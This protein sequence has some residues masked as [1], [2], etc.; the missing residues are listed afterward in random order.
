[1]RAVRIHNHGSYDV[2]QH[3]EIPRPEPEAGQVLI[4]VAWSALNH[5]DSWVRRGVP[6]HAFPLPMTPGCDFSGV[7]EVVGEGVEGWQ[8]GDRVAVSPGFS[9]GSCPRCERGEENLCRRYG[10]YGET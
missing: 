3:Q 5:L 8:E 7:V 6:G 10:I 4:K 2:L 9:C 1:M